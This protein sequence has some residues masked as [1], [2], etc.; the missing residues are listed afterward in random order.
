MLQEQTETS[1]TDAIV[2]ALR[3]YA[4]RIELFGSEARGEARADSDIDVLVTLR[5]EDQRP[6][7]GLSWFELEAKL[8]ERIGRPVRIVTERALSRHVRPHIAPDRTVLY[9]DESAR[10]AVSGNR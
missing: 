6:Q 2:A 9:D 8:S 10:D 4:S 3:P 5:P 1:I 7:L